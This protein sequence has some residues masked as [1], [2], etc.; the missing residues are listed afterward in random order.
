MARF[1][2]LGDI[3]LSDRPPSSCTDTYLDDLFDLLAYAAQI[4][5]QYS[6]DATV[7]A[8]DVFHYKQ[9]SRTSHKTMLRMI[10]AVRAFTKFIIVPGN[11]DMLNDRLD[12]I[13]E[14]QPLGVLAHAGAELLV[15]W[16][17]DNLPLYGVPWQQHWTEET[18]GV[19]LASYH[20]ERFGRALVVTHAPIYPP[21][22]ELEFEY[23]P[24]RD[25]PERKGWSSLLQD[26]GW[27]YY[28]H[29]HEPHGIYSVG[30]VT[31]ANQGALSRGSL[32]E[33]NLTRE[34][35]FTIWDEDRGIFAPVP[36]PH[37]PAS[38]V[39]RLVEAQEIKD[40]TRSLAD[41][42][43]GIGSATIEITSTE[44]VI[45]HIRTLGLDESVVRLAVELLQQQ[46]ALT[47]R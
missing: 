44:S 45:E 31:Y 20:A 34:I 9:P 39:F 33:Y 7:S 8:G 27:L 26:E 16:Q 37:K 38:E 5:K 28:G 32:H 36:V 1:L 41:F 40:N 3:H 15:G 6:C 4:E 21:G 22:Q 29:I 17:R 35:Q 14:T 19:A 12:S 11:H 10:D 24:T 42:L 18:I 2:I 25:E 46:G 13:T 43:A 30:G 47:G 23:Y